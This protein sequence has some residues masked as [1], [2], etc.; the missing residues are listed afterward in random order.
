MGIGVGGIV[1]GLDTEAIIAGMM[2][3][4]SRPIVL[5]QGREADF[6]AKITALG[7]LTGGLASLQ[8]SAAA[9]KDATGLDSFTATSGNTTALAV[10]AGTDAVAGTYQ[11]EVTSLATAQ[12]VRSAAFAG[13]DDV[14]GTGTLTIQVGADA[15]VDV[16]IDSDHETLAGIAQAINATEDIGVSATVVD[17]GN[18]NVYLTMLSNETGLANTITMT[19]SDDD[20][21]NTDGAGLSA[22]YTD[23]GAQTLTQTQ[24]ATN[25]ELTVN[26]IAV[27][28]ASNTIDD[29]LTGITMTLK[30][31][32]PGNPFQVT[33]TG[34]ASA[35]T[36]KVNEFVSKYNALVGV[37]DEFQ[38]YDADTGVGG[39]LQGDS[40]TR[41]LRSGLRNL[42]TEQ[43]EGVADEVNGL[44][45]LGVE[46][47]DDGLLTV[48]DT[49]LATAIADHRD[50]VITFF[51]NDEDGNDGIARRFDDFIDS[52]LGS[53][54]VLA[55]KNDGLQSSISGIDDQ[56]ERINLRLEQKE[57]TI[58]HQFEALEVLLANFEGTQGALDQQLESLSNLS[59]Y[60]SKK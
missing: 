2:E 43:V 14:V 16:A 34:D 60:I 41:Q 48:D 1:S 13:S 23:P 24:G 26:G 37:F 56:I 33:V 3:Y 25:A 52:Y 51:S 15:A 28:R 36:S 53:S 22:L 5:L 7:S 54:G 46:V 19:M 30:Q 12:Q 47:G 27:E 8:S 11:V 58:R 10:T 17:D 49:V 29:L 4:A 31:E 55:A 59:N 35:I 38:G 40:T 42:L 45:F 6:Q 50:D 18:G 57:R 9:L 32:D 20:G 39:L 21:D 44:S